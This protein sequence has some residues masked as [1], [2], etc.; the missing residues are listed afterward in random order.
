[1]DILKVFSDNLKKY[2]HQIDLSQEEFADKAGLHRTYISAVECGKRSISLDNIQKIADT[3][4]IDTYKLFLECDDVDNRI[5]YNWEN[6]NDITITTMCAVIN[7]SNDWL[8]INRTKSWT[9]LALPGGHIEGSE[10]ALECIKREMLEE[11]GLVLDSLIFKGIL[12]F[13]N[14]TTGKRY[15]IFNYLSTH[16]SGEL[17]TSC[18]EG[19]LLWINPK[20]FD[21]YQFAEGMEKRFGLFT[22]KFPTETFIE[23]NEVDG[24]IDVKSYGLTVNPVE[25]N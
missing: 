20:E 1:M 6:I 14:S 18:G 2:R 16:Y 8:F 21:N 17:K 15:I 19:T 13:Y 5:G 24:Y 11:T 25:R 7:N 12:H 3:L 23:W 22:Q 9:G 10:S 4:G